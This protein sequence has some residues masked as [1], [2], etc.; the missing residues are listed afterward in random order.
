MN[1]RKLTAVAAAFLTLAAL[2]LPSSGALADVFVIAHPSVQLATGDVRDVFVGDKQFAGSVKLIPVDNAPAQE[3]FLSK[4]LKME[5]AKYNSAWTKKS[6]REGL[7]PPAIK[8]GDAE[9][10]EFVKKTPGAVGYVTGQ[11]SGVTVVQ[12]F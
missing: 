4:A 1:T 3:Q 5:G 11:P 8:S 2:A 12:K 9:V 10:V 6:F 7:N